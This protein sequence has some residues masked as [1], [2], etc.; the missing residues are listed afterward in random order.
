M[1]VLRDKRRTVEEGCDS[2]ERSKMKARLGV[3]PEAVDEKPCR[4]IATSAECGGSEVKG[5]FGW[6][7]ITGSCVPWGKSTAQEGSNSIYGSDSRWKKKRDF[8]W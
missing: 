5:R 2:R 7:R 3:K 4:Q 8:S 1:I 6:V